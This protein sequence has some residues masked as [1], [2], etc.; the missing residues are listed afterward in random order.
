MVKGEPARVVGRSREIG[1]A[2]LE[3]VT[4]DDLIAGLPRQV[5]PEGIESV[6]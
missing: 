2:A 5:Y 3:Y 1:H 6:G 4:E